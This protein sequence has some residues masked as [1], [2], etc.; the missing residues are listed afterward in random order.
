MKRKYYYSNKKSEN[1]KA[2]NWFFLKQS[3]KLGVIMKK[4]IPKIKD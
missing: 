4:L 2:H 1:L 3:L